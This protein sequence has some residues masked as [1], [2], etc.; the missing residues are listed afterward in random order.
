MTQ[1]KPLAQ[2][3]FIKGREQYSK[4]DA[5]IYTALKMFEQYGY[6]VIE[7]PTVEFY[8][9][10]AASGDSAKQSMIKF[11]DPFG[12][13]MVLQADPT[14]SLAHYMSKHNV[15]LRKFAMV[16]SIHRAYTIHS[17]RYEHFKQIGIEVFHD[18]GH[19]DE[20]V[21]ELACK[22]LQHT[23][24]NQFVLEFGHVGFVPALLT[25]LNV[26][27]SDVPSL[28]SAIML[29]DV[30]SLD[31][32]TM[33]YPVLARTTIL[34][35]I[36]W[37]G[38]VAD[39]GERIA[40]FQLPDQCIDI[41]N[42][43]KAYV[44]YATTLVD[45]SNVIFDLSTLRSQEY[46]CGFTMC[47]YS[48]T[49]ATPILSGGRYQYMNQNTKMPMHA[50]GF[51]VDVSKLAAISPRQQVAI[52]NIAI[53]TQPALKGK[54]LML[55]NTLRNATTRVHVLFDNETDISMMDEVIPLHKE[56]L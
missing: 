43:C 51:G 26:P 45:E 10:M 41:V 2:G 8:D 37:F 31:A 36:H 39:V 40:P 5:I 27:V 33:N 48:N 9:V 42:T 50:I 7:P 21:I 23:C 34:D 35:V 25:G 44:M 1:Y 6:D 17:K 29:K 18:G 20:E 54:A 15:V 12:D 11:I 4:E 52:K 19:Y 53:I 47:A 24:G 13:I 56:H 22:T 38:S 46:Y 14:L 16:S 32:I 30:P 55:A 49:S 28:L 3:M